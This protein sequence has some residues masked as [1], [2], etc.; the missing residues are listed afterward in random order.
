MTAE[1]FKPFELLHLPSARLSPECLTCISLSQ[2][3]NRTWAPTW[4]AVPDCGDADSILFLETI[5][6]SSEPSNACATQKLARPWPSTCV[7]KAA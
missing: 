2:S 4:L 3:C 5:V 6:Y 7:P 1:A